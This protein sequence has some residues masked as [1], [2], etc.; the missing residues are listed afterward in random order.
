MNGIEFIKMAWDLLGSE[1]A[2]LHTRYEKLYGGP[3]PVVDLYRF[4]DCPWNER[5]PTLDQINRDMG[6]ADD[7]VAQRKSAAE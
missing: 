7:L 4:F 6:C 1:L 2:G 3:P 5:R